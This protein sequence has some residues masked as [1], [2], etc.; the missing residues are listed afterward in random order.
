MCL[1]QKHTEAKT[2]IGQDK[3]RLADF[4]DMWWDTYKKNPRHFI[5]PEQYKAVNAMRLCRTESLG[6]DHY[7]CPDCGEITQV[8]HSCKNRFCPTCSWQDTLKW[9]D[10]IKQK[11]L[12]LPHRHTVM[13]LPHKLNNLIKENNDKLLSALMR[14]S[15]DTMKEWIK[16]KYHLDPGVI[17]V[18]HTFGETK[19]YH[20]HTHMIVSWGGISRKDHTLQ[21]IKGEYVNY[22]FLKK[23]FRCK[24]EDELTALYDKGVLIHHF[25]DRQDFLRFL[26]SLN[27]QKWII[28]LEPPMQIPAEVIRYIGRY[29]KR[30]CL[31]EYKIT[32][33]EAENIAFR[34][35]DYKTTDKHNKPVERELELNFWEFFPRL[36][37]HVPLRYFRLVRYY[38]AYANRNQIP[39]QYLYSETEEE[40]ETIESGD[41]GSLQEEI[42]GEN[43]LICPHCQKRKVYIYTSIRFNN[44]SKQETFQRPELMKEKIP[45]KQVA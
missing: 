19:D 20:V 1:H 17:S 11:M 8:Y 13:T 30:A 27:K 43:P 34:Y 35:K 32:K 28:H 18:L 4:F 31:S 12:A 16:E 44:K 42:T 23:K 14:T 22:D 10:K 37:Q 2:A 5:T 39:Q 15:A 36:L 38:G 29:S 21:A 41:W 7:A 6:I 45:D 24:F 26:K 33:I 9:A 25:I 3:Y 40:K